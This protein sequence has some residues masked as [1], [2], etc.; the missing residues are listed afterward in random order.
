MLILILIVCVIARDKLTGGVH[1]PEEIER[2]EEK[3]VGINCK[4]LNSS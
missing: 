1:I 3:K 2:S 4:H